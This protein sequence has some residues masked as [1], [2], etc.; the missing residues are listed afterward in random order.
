MLAHCGA[1]RNRFS[2]L[3]IPEAYQSLNSVNNCVSKFRNKIGNHHLAFGAVYYPWLYSNIALGPSLDILDHFKLLEL[4]QVLPEPHAHTFLNSSPAPSGSYLHQ[5]LIGFSPTYMAMIEGIQNK[6]GLLPPSGF[7]AGIYART[8][9]ERGVW[10]APANVAINSVYK[11]A[12][13]I[14]DTEQEDLNRP[15]SGKSVNAIR[16]FSGNGIMVW[17]ARTLAGNDNEWRYIPTRRTVIMI[18]QSLEKDLQFA[19]FEPNTSNTWLTVKNSSTN[20]L[21]SIWSS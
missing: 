1:K 12:I 9:R 3:D 6:L 21:T 11:T 18:E 20:F 16:E 4:Q 2:I 19:I 7:I 14:S 15:S 17:G 13:S 8:D 5:G 10:K